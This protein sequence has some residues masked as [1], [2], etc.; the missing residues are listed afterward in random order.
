M[1]GEIDA[2][3]ESIVVR[4]D[5]LDADRHEIEMSALADSIKGL[6]RIFAV[7]GNFAATQ[8]YIQHKDAMAVR[9]VAAAPRPHCFEFLATIQWASQNPLIATT[10][11]GLFVVLVSWIFKR[12]AG[13]REEM[14]N[15]RGALETAIKELGTKDQATVDR[16]LDTVD[17]MADA[18]RP[19]AKQAVAPIGESVRTL[20]I[21]G[22]KADRPLVVDEAEKAA[23]VSE[24]PLEV[25]EERTY[26]VLITE[27]D[28]LSGN[29]H[30]SFAD[31]PESKIAGRITDPAFA[32]PNNKYALALAAKQVLAVR[33]KA[34]LRDGE[35][36]RLHISDTA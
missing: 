34:T 24:V 4:Y 29:C 26:H 12:A 7:A 23:I 3:G 27:L 15:L 2:L 9:V 16:L 30:M 14:K 11:G 19:A 5:G 6:A 25:G 22:A 36:D 10:V 33:A 21:T 8:R 13:R 18:L 28:M 1:A 20:T 31:E 35:I 32:S 17:K